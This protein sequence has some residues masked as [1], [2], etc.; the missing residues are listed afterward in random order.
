MNNERLT[1]EENERLDKE[2]AQS[3]KTILDNELNELN[4]AIE[5]E[6]D[7][8][9]EEYANILKQIEQDIEEECQTVIASA[10]QEEETAELQLVA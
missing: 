3:A 9:D 7:I 6:D 10:N 5:I 2:S 1:K 8:S 4:S